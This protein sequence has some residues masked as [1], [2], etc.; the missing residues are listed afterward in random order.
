ME[1]IVINKVMGTVKS[2]LP[3]CL[4]ALLLISFSAPSVAQDAAYNII[5]ERDTVIKT[6]TGGVTL[7]SRPVRRIIYEY[8][9]KDADGNPATISGVMMIPS[10]IVDG[11]P[12][13]GILLFN[14]ATLGSPDDCPT[15]GNQELINGLIA[16]PLKPNYILVMSDFIGYGS[17]SQY[18]SFYHSG[19]VN[20]RNSLDGLLAA[21][22]ILDDQ[23]LPQGKYL[24]N[25]GFS[26]GGSESLYVAKLR[27]MEYKDKG[28][29]FTKTFA[30]GGPTDYAVAYS[31]YVKKDWCEDC[32]DVI[33]MLISCVENC[34][35]DIDYKD[36]FKEPL[37]S[38]AKEYV[39]TKKK[40]TL[41]DYG[42]SME[43]SLHNLIQPAYMNL[44]SDQAK[45]F[46]AALEKINL[47]NGW[48][49]DITQKYFVEH[50]RHDNYVPIQCVRAIIPW[51]KEKGFKPS[52][53]PGKTNLQTNTLVF[54]LNHTTSA[55]VWL[56]QTVAA[57]QF[58]P[59]L[60]YEGEQNRYFHSVV[61]DL[62]LMKVIKYLES[63]GIDLRKLIQSAPGLE[64]DFSDG[65]ANGSIQPDGSVSQLSRRAS[66]FEIIG[67]ISDAL[68]KVDLTL[69]DAYEM[70][71]DS[72]ITIEN[73]MEVVNYLT[74]S[75]AAPAYDGADTL[76]PLEERVE[77]PL[78]LLRFYEQQLTNWFLLAGFDVNYN[79]WGM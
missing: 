35:L 79:Q 33:M 77:A 15:T 75:S 74:E 38:G 6:R 69:Q 57:I 36:L 70:L 9:S 7:S 31:E 72:G 10:E 64:D 76:S 71:D 32:K 21:R 45:A 44:Q 60:Y 14:R 58:W 53:V 2:L 41:S 73:I 28:V 23:Q 29:T 13:D 26:Q 59:V 30:G 67:K 68:A 34:H 61:G 54:K 42:V 24:F 56:I 66:F 27:D 48:E 3:F 52:I 47:M 25:L 16:N 51:M 20:A 19:D 8:T 65:I 11:T 1:T 39:K 5:Y 43:D 37:A 78:Y 40:S 49:P 50:S 62:N 22:Q 18:P 55:I 17:S 4:F 12:C 46:I 63:W